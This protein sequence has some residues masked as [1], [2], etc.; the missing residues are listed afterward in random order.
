MPFS[1][2]ASKNLKGIPC[3][4]SKICNSLPERLIFPF[5]Q[6][7]SVC[8]PLDCTP[9]QANISA[10]LI[11]LVCPNFVLSRTPQ[12][13]SLKHTSEHV[14]Y[15]TAPSS[16]FK[17]LLFFLKRK[18]QK[19]ISM[20]PVGLIR[21]KSCNYIKIK[22]FSFIILKKNYSNLSSNFLI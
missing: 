3:Y 14:F 19:Q 5:C 4:P 22:P 1:Q 7:A 18:K 17:C 8:R 11:L 6:G 16:A 13:P 21:S 15:R 20:P 10:H 2:E 12:I 9:E